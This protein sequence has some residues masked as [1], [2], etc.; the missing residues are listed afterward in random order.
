[1]REELLAARG[2]FYSIYAAI[3]SVVSRL[4]SISSLKEETRMATPFLMGKMFLLLSR[5]ASATVIDVDRQM[6]YPLTCQVFL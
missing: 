5:L 3:G 1:M 6:V 4:E 2:M